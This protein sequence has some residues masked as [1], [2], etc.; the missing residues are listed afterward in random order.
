MPDDTPYRRLRKEAERIVRKEP[1]ALTE[2]ERLDLLR[3]TH[4]LELARTELE[5]QYKELQRTSRQL[6]ASRNEFIELYETAP[7]AFVSLSIKGLIERANTVARALL[8]GEGGSPIGHG[9]SQFVT[10]RHHGRYFRAM[11]KVASLN[12]GQSFELKL[13]GP[14]DRSFHAHILAAPKFGADR[15]FQYWHLAFFDVTELRRREEELQ[16]IHAQLQMAA[17]A[18]R[19][20]TWTYD[21]DQSTTQWDRGLYRLLRLKPREG[22]EAGDYFFEFIHPDDRTGILKNLQA[23]LAKEGNEIR[24]EFRVVRADGEVRWL[25]ARGWIFRDADGRPSHVAGIN[26]DITER[27]MQEQKVQLAQLQLAQQLSATERANEE[28]SQYAYAASH[29]L[30]GPLRAIRNYA[31]FLAEDLADTLTGEQKKYLDGMIKAVQQGDDLINDLLNLSRIDRFELEREKADI[32]AIVDEIRALLGVSS[33]IQ[34][35]VESRWPTL[36]SD[37]RLLRQI[38]HNLIDNAVKFNRRSPREVAV[39]W[40]PAAQD[41]IEL[42]VRDNG[43]GIAP[44][45]AEQIFRIFQRLHTREDYDGTGIGLAIVR[46]AAHKLG[47]TVR[48]ESEPEKGSTFYVLL[49]WEMPED[50]A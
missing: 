25:A 23:L 47:G 27:K 44:Q 22:P 2:E 9:F 1:V 32:P 33:D 16:Q 3:L 11:R 26:F 18:A 49:P 34:I 4:E 14:R 15:R 6:E 37:Y 10:P 43:I 50:P 24:E 30:K 13:L 46:K 28:L 21:L 40:Q 39:G 7:V 42:F 48:L 12:E 8:S 41:Y 19:L 31:D 38:L 35:S 20:G 5:V 36:R 45:Y 29:D 17:R